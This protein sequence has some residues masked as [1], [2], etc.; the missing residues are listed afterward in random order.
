[1]IKLSII[2]VSYNTAFLL[3]ECIQ[4]ILSS[5]FSFDYEIIV[6]DNHSTDNTLEI[7]KSFPNVKVVSNAKNLLFAKANNLGASIA[8]G[9]YLL[10]LNSDTLIWGD[11]IDRLVKYFDVVDDSVICIGPKI[12]NEDRS[13]QSEGNFGMTHWDTIVK[14][15]KVGQ[16]F[17][18]FIVKGILPPGTYR[19]NKNIPHA[20]AWVSGACMLIRADLYSSVGGLNEKLEFYGEEPEF[21]FRTS[22]LGYRTLYYPHSEIVH[23]G[24]K[25]TP[26]SFKKKEDT[27]RRYTILVEQTV[28]YS[29]AIWTSR[30]TRLSYLLKYLMTFKSSIRALIQYETD[31]IKYIKLKLLNNSNVDIL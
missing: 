27:L 31:V 16:I 2:I 14:H 19:F 9:K 5:S 24:G 4:S 12:L 17:P 6:V 25:S 7:L 10:L 1:M 21:G 26:Q 3:K 23:L 13:V 30:I 22:N 8:K 18:K 28:G 15:F 29:Y 20:V 11:N